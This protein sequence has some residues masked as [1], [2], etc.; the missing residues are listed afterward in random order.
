MNKKPLRRPNPNNPQVASYVRAVKKGL[1]AQHVVHSSKGWS[2][3]RAG[4]S[5]ASGVFS[6]QEQ[7]QRAAT[8]I[9][10]NNKT[11]VFIHGRDGRIRDRNSFGRDPFPPRG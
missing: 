6:T 3:K 1:E 7:A 2:V 5:R 10:K 9:A 11:E 8:Q 4:A